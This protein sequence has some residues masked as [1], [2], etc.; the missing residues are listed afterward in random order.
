MEKPTPQKLPIFSPTKI[1]TFIECPTKYKYVYVDRIGRFYQ[2]PHAY[3][4]FGTTLHQVLQAYHSPG[5]EQSVEF[6][7]SQLDDRWISAGYESVDEEREYRMRAEE[8]LR[9]YH[10]RALERA[11]TVVTDSVE[12]NLSLNLGTFKLSG[13]IDRIDVHPDGTVEVVDYKSGRDD[14]TTG[15]V[16]GSLAMRCYMLLASRTML[17]T[18]I[19]GTIIALRTCRSASVAITHEQLQQTADEITNLANTILTTNITA[20]EPVRIE[21]C[22]KC[23]FLSRCQRTWK[24][25]AQ[26]LAPSQNSRG[27]Y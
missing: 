3:F 19:I 23:E 9:L 17:A 24:S 1:S 27:E 20:V 18:D 14:V 6:L 21:V 22:D 12:R 16:Y 5:G 13:R 15:D 10:Q 26:G 25:R 8:V 4:S 2:K 7:L 11:G